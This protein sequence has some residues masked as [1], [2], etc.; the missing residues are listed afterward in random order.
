MSDL[1]KKED[2]QD[3]IQSLAVKRGPV[4]NIDKTKPAQ[5]NMYGGH[6]IKETSYLAVRGR[7]SVTGD[8]K[9]R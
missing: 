2:L 9:R 4:D 5:N 7:Y 1:V 3:Y 6:C 8:L